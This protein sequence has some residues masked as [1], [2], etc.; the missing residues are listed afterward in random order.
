[1]RISIS[2]AQCTG[3]TTL[4]QDLKLQPELK[5]Y[6]FAEE[7]VRSLKR[8]AEEKG[9]VFLFNKQY[10]KTSQDSIFQEHINNLGYENLVADRSL[11]DSFVYTTYGFYKGEVPSQD[12]V[13]YENIFLK[14][15]K[16]Y[17]IFFFLPISFELVADGV[18][19]DD[20]KFREEIEEIFLRTLS[21]YS[22]KYQKLNELNNRLSSVLS[23]LK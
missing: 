21:S 3:K 2:G 11:L 15:I 4:I 23:V 5:Q 19:S 17:D 14:N 16:K 6:H 8:Q 1:M 7:V 18:R 12:F 22:I 10:D 20:K 9:E 13:N